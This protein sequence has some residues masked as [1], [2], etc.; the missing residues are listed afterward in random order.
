MH[1]NLDRTIYRCYHADCDDFKLVNEEHLRNTAR[2]GSMLLYG[3][4]DAKRLPAMRMDS[5]QTRRFLIENN[6]KQPLV[7]AGDWKWKD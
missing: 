6:L 1:S 5:E 7:I 2:F 4:A 3:I